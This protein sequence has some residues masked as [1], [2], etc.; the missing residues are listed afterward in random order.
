MPRSW[1]VRIFFLFL[2]VLLL[3]YR[4]RIPSLF[5]I[6][7]CRTGIWRKYWNISGTFRFQCQLWIQWCFWIRCEDNGIF[8]PL[9]VP[10]YTSCGLHLSEKLP[11]ANDDWW[12]RST[13]S[14]P[15]YAKYL[16]SEFGY[17]DELNSP[18]SLDENFIIV[19]VVFVFTKGNQLLKQFNTILR[20]VLKGGIRYRYWEQLNHE[21]L[22]RGR[23]K[24]VEDD[25]MTYFVFKLSHMGP[26]F[27]VLGFGYLFSTIVCIAECLHKRFSK[28]WQ[29]E[30]QSYLS[31]K[32]SWNWTVL[33]AQTR[34]LFHHS[35][36]I[37]ILLFTTTLQMLQQLAL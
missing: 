7:S 2:C 30:R 18:C 20:R 25:S 24:S 16:S 15:E 35:C 29:A 1:K 34:L 36:Y 5:P 33:T 23:T 14:A 11:N 28:W 4:H 9:V 37:V 32:T 27:S 3:C 26:A 6:V 8:G 10:T 22:L 19:G 21:A 13:I 31:I 17:K 12:R